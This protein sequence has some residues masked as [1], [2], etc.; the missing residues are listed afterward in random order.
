M[1]RLLASKLFAR[2]CPEACKGI[3]DVVAAFGWLPK[4]NVKITI[5]EQYLSEEYRE[6]KL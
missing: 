1:D 6:S 4:L 3:Q 2:E 5:P